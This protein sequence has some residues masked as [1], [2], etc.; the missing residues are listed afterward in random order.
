[1]SQI[2]KNLQI[3]GQDIGASCLRVL[4]WGSGSHFRLQY[5]HCYVVLE[6]L[7]LGF[8]LSKCSSLEMNW[9][10]RKRKLISLYKEVLPLSLDQT[11]PGE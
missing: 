8:H 11:E 4:H 10:A 6:C 1:M 7:Q 5:S 2:K 3:S 9:R